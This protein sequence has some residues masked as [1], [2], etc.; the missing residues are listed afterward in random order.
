[1]DTQSQHFSDKSSDKTHIYERHYECNKDEFMRKQ[2][3]YDA[4]KQQYSYQKIKPIGN[5]CCYH[6]RC[7]QKNKVNSQ[8]HNTG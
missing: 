1:M 2:G 5:S 3:A 4:R 7:T 6:C 8:V